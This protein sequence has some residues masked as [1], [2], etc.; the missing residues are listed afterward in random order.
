MPGKVTDVAGRLNQLMEEYNLNQQDIIKKCQPYC[1]QYGVKLGHVNMSNYV[2][3]I[4]V[5]NAAKLSILGMAL[6]VSEVWLMGYDVPRERLV[7]IALN[8][9]ELKLIAVYRSLDESGKALIDLMIE[10]ESQ[11]INK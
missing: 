4:N 7:Q 3:G 8:E 6:N 5:P 11:R 10:R 1:K 9:N 2:N